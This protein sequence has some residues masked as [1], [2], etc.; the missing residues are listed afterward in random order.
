MANNNHN[1]PQQNLKLD[2]SAEVAQ[3]TYSNLAIISH[4]PTEIILDFAQMLPGTPNATVRSR[5]LMNPVHA[6]RLLNAL[7]DN[8]QKYE[9]NFGSIEEPK[10]PIS[11]DT[12]P[13]DILGK[14]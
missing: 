11:G 10:V 4:S 7:A 8:I 6:K 1:N 9:Q 13:Y 5:V 12:V 14:A 3:G 2:L